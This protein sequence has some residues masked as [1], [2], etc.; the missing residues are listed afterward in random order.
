M[1][2][3]V[4][5]TFLF[6]NPASF[7][8]RLRRAAEIY[9]SKPWSDVTGPQIISAMSFFCCI[10]VVFNMLA[11]NCTKCRL[12]H[13]DIWLP[14]MQMAI[15]EIS[16]CE[17]AQLASLLLVCSRGFPISCWQSRWSWLRL[18][19][20]KGTHTHKCAAADVHSGHFYSCAAF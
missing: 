2:F 1:M 4:Q 9:I 16:V 15:W 18:S 10:C 17:Y 14:C 12:S 11:I 5:G 19:A 6:E 13:N 7:S 3:G 20:I 8:K